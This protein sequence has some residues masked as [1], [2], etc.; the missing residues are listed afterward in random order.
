MVKAST[1]V[2]QYGLVIFGIVAPLL[3]YILK[4]LLV[5]RWDPQ[6][7][8]TRTYGTLP[9]KVLWHEEPIPAEFRRK[10]TLYRNLDL[11]AAAVWMIIFLVGT[12][13]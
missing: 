7:R 2:L 5:K 12:F 3:S 6:G 11:S 13:S 9:P 4:E 10:W 8:F 1:Q